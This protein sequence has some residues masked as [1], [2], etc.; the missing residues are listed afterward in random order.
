[1][2]TMTSDAIASAKAP[3]ISALSTPSVTVT[4][5]STG[6]SVLPRIPAVGDPELQ[7]RATAHLKASLLVTKMVKAGGLLPVT[8]S[9]KQQMIEALAEELL[10]FAPIPL[11]VKDEAEMTPEELVAVRPGIRVIMLED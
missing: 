11:A 8:A 10:I 9:Q 5:F 1:M 2:A 6:T 4:P 3:G 7:R